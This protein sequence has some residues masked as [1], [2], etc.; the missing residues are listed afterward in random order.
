MGTENKRVERARR[1]VFVVL[2]EAGIKSRDD[3]LE[4]AEDVLGKRIN[5]FSD[6]TDDDYLDLHFGLLAWR[7]VQDVRSANGALLDEAVFLIEKTYDLDLSQ[8]VKTP[9]APLPYQDD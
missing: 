9:A 2:A 7:R 3:R 6:L 5:S 1:G 8:H 4:L